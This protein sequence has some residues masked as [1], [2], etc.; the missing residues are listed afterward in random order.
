MKEGP[1]GEGLVMVEGVSHP[2]LDDWN[3]V[4]GEMPHLSRREASNQHVSFR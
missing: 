4:R 3:I 2:W 1:R